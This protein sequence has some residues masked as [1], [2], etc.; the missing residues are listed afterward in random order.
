GVRAVLA[1]IGFGLAGHLVVHYWLARVL[2]GIGW[3]FLFVG[4]TTQLVQTYLSGERFKAQ[5]VNEFSVFGVSALASLFAGT[6]IDQLGW[7]PLL[8]TSLPPLLLMLII[9][10]R[11]RHA[12]DTDLA[13]A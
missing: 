10:F 5:A 3:N 4:G 8:L 7:T 9:L 6:L 13:R 12:P 2:L 11:T 1:A